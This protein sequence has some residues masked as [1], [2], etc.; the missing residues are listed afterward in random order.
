MYGD[1]PAA[2]QGNRGPSLARSLAEPV[3]A[4]VHL[5]IV[6]RTVLKTRSAREAQ[7]LLAHRQCQ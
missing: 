5:M 2:R 6:E 7:V 3:V 4:R 1:L